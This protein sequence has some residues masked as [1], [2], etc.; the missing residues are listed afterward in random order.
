MPISTATSKR[1]AG[2][3]VSVRTRGHARRNLCGPRVRRWF[4]PV[5]I[6][7]DR[8]D[9]F[10]WPGNVRQL[11]NVVSRAIVR[12]RDGDAVVGRKMVA[13]VQREE[14]S[15]SLSYEATQSGNVSVPAALDEWPTLAEVE[16]RYIAR[17]LDATG[18]SVTESARILGIHRS[19]V[20]RRRETW[21]P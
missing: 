10:E 8:R 15:L 2:T 11:F 18:G 6:A 9:R 13:E 5:S 1:R 14:R 21:D 12:S 17:V 20:R 7:S 4:L 19:T 3:V 16:D